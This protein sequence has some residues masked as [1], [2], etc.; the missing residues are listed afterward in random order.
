MKRTTIC[1]SD[2]VRLAVAIALLAGAGPLLAQQPTVIQR[3]IQQAQRAAQQAG[4]AAQQTPADAKTSTAPAAA[5]MQQPM[6]RPSAMQQVPATHTVQRGETLWAL[7]QQFLGDALLWPEIYRLNTTVVED[8]HWIFPGEEL[9]LVGLPETMAAAPQGAGADTTGGGNLALAP[10]ADSTAPVTVRTRQLPGADQPTI[11]A[12]QP[13]RGSSAAALEIADSRAYRGVR[14][15]EYYASGFIADSRA[16]EAGVLGSNADKEAL[17]RLVSRG[18]ATL[19]ANVSVTP[20]AGQAYH[21]GDLLL[22]YDVGRTI[23]GYGEIIRPLGLLRVTTDGEAGQ[24]VM[25]TVTALYQ[26]LDLGSSVMKV[27]EF[28][29]DSNAHSVAVDSG[30]SGTV[31]ATRREGELS[32]VQDVLYLS[33]GADDGVHL[34]DVFRVSSA[35]DANGFVRDQADVLVVH[36]QPHTAT[37]LVLQ[38]TQPDIRPGATVRRTRR[39]PT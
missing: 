32:S 1:R 30:I 34:G 19:Y 27:D 31:V 13:A 21:R 3:P 26:Q 6:Q 25:A 35:P 18:T 9:R 11:F 33:I 23:V 16:L 38:V 10:G 14:V 29:Y 12:Q 2:S 39:M 4:Q 22:A 28:H 5:T 37:V 8:P 17:R 20:P 36:L 24:V 7:A 15:G